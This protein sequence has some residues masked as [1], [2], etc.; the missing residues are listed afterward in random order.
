MVSGMKLLSLFLAALVLVS[1]STGSTAYFAGLDQ[2][3][4]YKRNLLV[5]RVVTAQDHQKKAKK[6]I[7]AL[8]E[9]FHET[10]SFG[11]EECLKAYPPLNLSYQQAR[12]EVDR[13]QKHNRNL[14]EDGAK[15]FVKWEREIDAFTDPG[16]ADENSLQRDLTKDRFD[17]LT[18]VMG[19]ADKLYDPVLSE[20]HD[21]VIYLKFNLNDEALATLADKTAE[22]SRDVHQLI[23][24]LESSIDAGDT[25]IREVKP[26]GH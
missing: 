12:A 4:S 9:Q 6:Q 5:A 14:Y 1:C 16:L 8:L 7:A 11:A 20:L 18:T 22:L 24:E 19:R 21:R 26:A 3:N 2:D 23:L 17:E 10:S 25:F 13:V 15:V